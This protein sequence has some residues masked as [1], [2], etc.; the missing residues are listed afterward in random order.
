MIPCDLKHMIR[1]IGDCLYNILYFSHEGHYIQLNVTEQDN[2]YMIEM[3]NPLFKIPEEYTGHLF[4]RYAITSL[5]NDH[6]GLYFANTI[7]QKHGGTLT[8][9]NSATY[10]YKLILTLPKSSTHILQ[11][12]DIDDSDLCRQ[13]DEYLEQSFFDL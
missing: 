7:I 2:A 4:T 6:A 13:I 9:D 8:F 10:G 3:I 5:G 12:N 11:F 1:A